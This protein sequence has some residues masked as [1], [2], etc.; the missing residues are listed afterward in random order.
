MVIWASL[1]THNNV[2]LWGWMIWVV[3]IWN[4]K[5]YDRVRFSNFLFFGYYSSATW[6]LK[7]V[8]IIINQKNYTTITRACQ[9]W[10]ARS[11]WQGDQRWSSGRPLPSSPE[12]FQLLLWRHWE[13]CSATLGISFHGIG[14]SSPTS[15]S[16]ATL[17][18]CHEA[19]LYA[20]QQK[21]K[22][23]GENKLCIID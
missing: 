5:V 18:W 12:V 13:H 7:Y 17:Q 23:Y 8:C 3:L 1:S 20:L 16:W 9:F 22:I 6:N 10:C 15:R 11:C 14:W 19:M 4:K 21:R 2:F